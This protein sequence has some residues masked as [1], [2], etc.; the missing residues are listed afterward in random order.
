MKKDIHPR[1][2]P[3]IF[4]D[5]KSGLKILTRSTASSKQKEKW[6]D[7]KEY[8]IIKVEISSASHPFYPNYKGKQN[9]LDTTGRVEL[10]RRKYAKKATPQ[11][12]S[13]KKVSPKNVVT[14]A[15]SIEKNSSSSK[16]KKK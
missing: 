15:S 3:I 12:T 16:G 2:E 14:K 5:T 9:L 13:T 8:P 6:E 11:K 10:F 7:G 1:Y 4:H